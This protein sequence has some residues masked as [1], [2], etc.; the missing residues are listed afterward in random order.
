M[1]KADLCQC[2]HI[3]SDHE[4]KTKRENYVLI[5]KWRGECEVDVCPCQRFRFK[6]VIGVR[7]SPNKRGKYTPHTIETQSEA[8]QM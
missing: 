4:F 3:K 6:K 1:S 5:E 8:E 7:Y 2:N